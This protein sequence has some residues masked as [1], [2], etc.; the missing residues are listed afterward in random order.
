MSAKMKN[1]ALYSRIFRRQSRNLKIINKKVRQAAKPAVKSVGVHY[2]IAEKTPPGAKI[3]HSAA[4]NKYLLRINNSVRVLQSSFADVRRSGIRRAPLFQ[5][6]Y[7][8][9][10]G[11]PIP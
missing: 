5:Q 9:S 10:Y 8:R 11:T 3:S 7:V 6:L 2:I 4:F 1:H